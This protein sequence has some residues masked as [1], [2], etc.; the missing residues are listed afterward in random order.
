VLTEFAQIPIYGR[1]RITLKCIETPPD[2]PVRWLSACI[3]NQ[4]TKELETRLMGP[5]PPSASRSYSGD[6]DIRAGSTPTSSALMAN[7]DAQRRRPLSCSAPS[8]GHA[9]SGVG[10]N[11]GMTRKGPMWTQRALSY[12]PD[13]KG[14]FLS[15][16]YGQMSAQSAQPV[17][18]LE[19]A[20][21]VGVCLAVCLL[22]DEGADSIDSE[23]RCALLRIAHGG[24]SKAPVPRSLNMDAAATKKTVT[25]L[26]VMCFPRMA[27]PT[28]SYFCATNIL[29]QLRDDVTIDWLPALLVSADE[30]DRLFSNHLAKK[31][32]NVAVEN[33]M[34]QPA[35]LVE[36][37]RARVP[38]FKKDN[39]KF[40]F[41][42]VF[43]ADESSAKLK[44]DQVLHSSGLRPCW[45][46]AAAVR[47]LRV[48]CGTTTVA[49]WTLLSNA[50]TESQ[51]D[52]V[53]SL[54]G[55]A[56]GVAEEFERY[57]VLGLKATIVTN[58][59]GLTRCPLSQPIDHNVLL[60]GWKHHASVEEMSSPKKWPRVTAV[61]PRCLQDTLFG[62]Q[63]TDAMLLSSMNFCRMV[64]SSTGDVRYW[65]VAMFLK[66]L[67][68]DRTPMQAMISDLLPCYE[69][70]LPTTGQKATADNAA[71]KPCGNK[72]Y[73]LNCETALEML[74]QTCDLPTIVDSLVALV[75]K[76]MTCWSDNSE[77]KWHEKSE[78][79]V[80]HICGT[81]CPHSDAR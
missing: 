48:E 69:R 59:I 34:V 77:V 65:S 55:Q 60:D 54:F 20:W 78:C 80:D 27:V 2:D 35:M 37:L 5:S 18:A 52:A 13:R 68:Y 45:L 19:P 72:R 49:E 67:G 79:V 31:G 51:D 71:G 29:K 63:P 24:E 6:L 22:C 43:T 11:I 28:L 76:T 15:E 74:L 81:H 73:C 14:S 30:Q 70:I 8:A 39:V 40:L 42:N 25:V 10:E 7:Q 47:M 16:V 21:Q 62:D 50:T 57:M 58:P 61:F 4:K 38:G 75:T 9:N 32:C 26:P 44:A 53:S 23:V 36:H 17:Q 33:V 1:K 41:M 56:L 46:I 12:Y 64:H 3:R 66:T